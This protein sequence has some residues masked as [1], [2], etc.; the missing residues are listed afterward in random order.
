MVIENSIYLFCL[1][2]LFTYNM[3]FAIKIN[4]KFIY[5]DNDNDIDN[6]KLDKIFKIIDYNFN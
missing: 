5:N 6:D 1:L 4:S 2:N 3:G